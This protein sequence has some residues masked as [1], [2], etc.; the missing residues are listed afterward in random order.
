M[1]DL[2]KQLELIAA[3]E[4]L[5]LD[6]QGLVL[7]V[8]FVCDNCCPMMK[9]RFCSSIEPTPTLNGFD[10]IEKDKN[11]VDIWYLYCVIDTPI[12]VNNN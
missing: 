4:L 5:R 9:I 7:S 8:C 6:I 10:Y 2:S 11:E 1:L 3:R 12:Q